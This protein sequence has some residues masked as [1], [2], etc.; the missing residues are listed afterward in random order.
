MYR[1]VDSHYDLESWR[2]FRGFLW[3]L[4]VR[5]DFESASVQNPQNQIAQT[6]SLL[7]FLTTHSLAPYPF[8]H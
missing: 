3:I 5:L 6:L 8:S 4:G 7:L 2:C 1:L